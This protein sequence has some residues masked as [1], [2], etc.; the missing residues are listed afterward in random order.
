MD[1]NS[2]EKILV[3]SMG[4]EYKDKDKSEY[5]D[6]LKN[7]SD[8]DYRSFM[9]SMERESKMELINGITAQESELLF[10]F[11]AE[12]LTA[13]MNIFMKGDKIKMMKNLDP[14]FLI[15]MVQELPLDLTQIILTQIDSRDFSEILAEDFRDILSSVVLFSSAS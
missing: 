5:I 10:L 11:E 12:D 13:P 9:L 14:E 6:S 2:L 3:E 8:D 4:E 7:L 15:P 1:R